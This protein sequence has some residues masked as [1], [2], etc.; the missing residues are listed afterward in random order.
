MTRLLNPSTFT[1]GAHLEPVRNFL[2]SGESFVILCPR[3]QGGAP[4]LLKDVARVEL[5]PDERRG[6]AP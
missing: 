6:V 1:I 4:V 5:T 2:E 3:A